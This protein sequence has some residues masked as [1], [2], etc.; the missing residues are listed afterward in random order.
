MERLAF[1]IIASRSRKREQCGTR[2]GDAKPPRGRLEM[3]KGTGARCAGLELLRHEPRG[4]DASY[5]SKNPVDARRVETIPRLQRI[6]GRPIRM[7]AHEVCAS[8]MRAKVRVMSE[9]CRKLRR[10]SCCV[11]ETLRTHTIRCQRRAMLKTP[12]TH[13]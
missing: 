12:E 5:R 10:A 8:R 1:N 6:L 13:R 9:A 11:G 4:R 2:D 7:A 3:P